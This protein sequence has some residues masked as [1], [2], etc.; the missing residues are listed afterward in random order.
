MSLLSTYLK[1]KLQVNKNIK[2]GYNYK[3]KDSHELRKIIVEKVKEENGGTEKY[4]V[5]LND[6]DVSEITD[7]RN[8]FHYVNWEQKLTAI[9]ISGWDMNKATDLSSMFIDCKFLKKIGDISGWDIS[10][11]TDIHSMF[12]GCKK[13]KNI[14][15]IGKWKVDNVLNFNFLFK[16]C[17]K[18]E[19]INIDNWKIN[20][21]VTKNGAK[22]IISGTAGWKIP[23]WVKQLK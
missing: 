22:M 20:N 6:I 23:T 8:L 9:D 18:L 13:I 4:P 3:P 1:E 15:N 7:F 19:P 11:V 12:S 5:D 14:G 21:T 10:N 16:N 2:S 17:E